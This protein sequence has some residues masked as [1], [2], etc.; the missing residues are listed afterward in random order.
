MK[1]GQSVN[2]QEKTWKLL[3]HPWAKQAR[4]ND[5]D[6]TVLIRNQIV[7]YDSTK[8]IMVGQ[9]DISTSVNL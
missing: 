1:I 3:A 8:K 2:F 4:H 9:Y 6:N 5:I 7:R